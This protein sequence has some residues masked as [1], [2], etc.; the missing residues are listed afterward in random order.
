MVCGVLDGSLLPFIF[1]QLLKIAGWTPAI[2]YTAQ[3]MMVPVW[4]VLLARWH[5]KPD[6]RKEYIC[7]TKDGVPYFT[8]AQARAK[9]DWRLF[10]FHIIP[11]TWFIIILFFFYAAITNYTP[12][13]CEYGVGLFGYSNF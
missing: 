9:N 1:L 5:P 3:V 8:P 10:L 11:T 2:L 12:P 6:K 7:Y 13:F 4:H